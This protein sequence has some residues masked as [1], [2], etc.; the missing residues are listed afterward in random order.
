[1]GTMQANGGGEVEYFSVGF[2]GQTGEVRYVVDGMIDFTG[3]TISADCTNGKINFNAVV[4]SN[5]DAPAAGKKMLRRMRV[6][7]NG[8]L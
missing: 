5:M 3:A 7:R 8:S 2:G 1:M 6:M 4:G